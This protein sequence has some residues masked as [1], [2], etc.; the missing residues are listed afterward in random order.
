MA[1]PHGAIM[2]SLR[3][4]VVDESDE[5]RR[6]V[7]DAIQADGDLRVVGEAARADEAALVVA[8]ERP[9]LAT[10]D[11]RLPELLGLAA[12]DRILQRHPVAILA[13]TS[14][15]G[16]TRG[17]L[18]FQ[19]VRRGAL[20]VA[21]K[22]RT[23]AEADALRQHV[24][25]L[26][27]TP[28]NPRRVASV[29]V[30][31]Y[32]EPVPERAAPIAA[33]GRRI[34]AIACSAG[35]PRAVA[36]ILAAL[37]GDFPATV[38]IVQHLP[39][40]FAAPFARYLRGQT[41]LRVHAVDRPTFIEPSTVYVAPGDRPLA[42]TVGDRL[43]PVDEP[44]SHPADSLFRTLAEVYGPAAIGIVLSG[45]GDDGTEGLLAMRARGAL[46]IAQDEGTSIVYGMPRAA[47]DAGAVDKVLPLGGMAPMLLRLIA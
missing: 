6:T 40:G 17:E 10:V 34:V 31:A 23:P 13:L 39:A 7:V 45:I 24:R 25:R 38:I 21:S 18:V 37:P 44:A 47:R 20:D 11:I 43:V 26:A 16:S 30:P 32:T 3:V 46:T 5:E 28:V 4:V 36:T 1:A 9:D 8:A 12:I 27:A 14:Q 15:A 41:R 29:P 2:K 42:A 19:A 22:P 35:G 33:P